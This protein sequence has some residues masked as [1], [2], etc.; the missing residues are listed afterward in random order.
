MKKFKWRCIICEKEIPIDPLAPDDDNDGTLPCI[1]GGTIEIHFGW[2]SKFDQFQDL[3]NRDIR[4]QSCICDS[5]FENKKHLT[6][7]IEVKK[8]TKYVPESE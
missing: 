8:M 1:E 4:I 2:F 7:Q 6:R 5:C 3:S